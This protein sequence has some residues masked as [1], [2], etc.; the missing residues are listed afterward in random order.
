MACLVKRLH[1]R[2]Q[3]DALALGLQAIH[4]VCLVAQESS[5]FTSHSGDFCG[6]TLFI[7]SDWS[8]CASVRRKA[9]SVKIKLGDWRLQMGVWQTKQKAESAG[10]Q[11]EEPRDDDEQGV[12][13]SGGEVDLGTAGESGEACQHQAEQPA[14]DKPAEV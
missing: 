13:D 5:L 10:T 3:P 11:G 12:E 14:G 6:R 4:R 2:T 8:S 9:G 1:Q 7:V